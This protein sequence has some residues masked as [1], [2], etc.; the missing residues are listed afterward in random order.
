MDR[1]ESIDRTGWRDLRHTCFFIP[2]LLLRSR[3][4]TASHFSANNGWLQWR[5]YNLLAWLT[6]FVLNYFGGGF[7]SLLAG[8]VPFAVRTMPVHRRRRAS[9][10][11]QTTLD[12]R[13]QSTPPF[14]RIIHGLP[15]LQ[16]AY[17][18]WR[19]SAPKIN[20]ELVRIRLGVNRVSVHQCGFES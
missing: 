1:F 19:S 6:C 5:R 14:V 11:L 15:D 8:F 20:R 12:R 2:S 17:G 3:H 13:P 4:F 18:F 7:V 9:P 10:T 16:N